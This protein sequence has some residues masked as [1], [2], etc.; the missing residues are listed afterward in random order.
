MSLL[1]ILPAPT[2]PAQTQAASPPPVAP[3]NVGTSGAV[4]NHDTVD[5]SDNTMRSVKEALEKNQQEIDRQELDNELSFGDDNAHQATNNEMA[6]LRF[7]VDAKRQKNP[8]LNLR[9]YSDIDSLRD[10][11]EKMPADGHRRIVFNAKPQG[12]HLYGAIYVDARKNQKGEL[13]LVAIVPSIKSEHLFNRLQVNP[14]ES[15]HGILGF[16]V[17]VTNY[18]NP[19]ITDDAVICLDA[20]SDANADTFTALHQQSPGH[21][22]HGDLKL[23]P[24]ALRKFSDPQI[25]RQEVKRL[26]FDLMQAANTAWN[27]ISAERAL[28]PQQRHAAAQ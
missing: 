26:R 16:L 18:G 12:K 28:S 20:A 19:P 9:I 5:I 15:A 7:V 1:S 2:T 24:E 17:A 21:V 13:S 23:L 27:E 22:Q 6:I 10:G 25:R 11:L 8:D 14:V 3:R 4:H